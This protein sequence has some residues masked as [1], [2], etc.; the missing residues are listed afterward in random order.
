MK[1]VNVNTMYKIMGYNWDLEQLETKLRL[2]TEIV[3]RKYRDR[4]YVSNEKDINFPA[5]SRHWSEMKYAHTNVISNSG[6]TIRL[7]PNTVNRRNRFGRLQRL[8]NCD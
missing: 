6:L 7:C 1:I 5:L 8:I 2:N 4:Y 3:Q